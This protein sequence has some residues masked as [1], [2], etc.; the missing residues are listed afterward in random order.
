MEIYKEINGFDGYMIS[1]YGNVKSLE[2]DV[3]RTSKLGNKYEYHIKGRVLKQ[4]TDKDGYK[5]INLFKDGNGYTLKIHRLVAE[6][7]LPNPENLPIVNHKDC[8][9]ANNKVEN[10]EWCTYSYNITYNEAG[11]KRALKTG[12][13][14][15]VFKDGVE[16][17]RY[18]SS[19]EA[20]EALGCAS[21]NIR[22][23]ARGKKGVYTAKGYTFSHIVD[24]V[25][26]P[27][28][29]KQETK[30][31]LQCTLDGE[32]VKEWSSMKEASSNGFRISCISQCC[33][34]KQIKHKGYIWK[35]KD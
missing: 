8:N 15:A 32:I 6:A 30:H 21:A 27:I 3:T 5:L 34:G 31:I 17:G 28:R 14:I 33:N 26:E 4:K 11:H 18:I 16:V 25:A 9:P 23:I 20:A 2:R 13:P 7:F 1:N 35:F 29:I 19:Y 24:G 10:L 22:S 12:K